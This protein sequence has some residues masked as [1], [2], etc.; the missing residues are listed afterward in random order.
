MVDWEL[1]VPGM[2][3]TILGLAGVGLSLAGIARTFVE[4]MH[5]ISALMM[6]IGMIIFA[7][8]VL[9]DGLPSS[10]QAKATVLIIVGFL[11][12]FGTFMLGIS[13]VTSLPMFAGIL[14]LILIPTA[15]IAW[16]A[17]KQSPHL[18]A[19]SILFSSASVVGVI[20]FLSFGLVAPQPIEAGV[21]E[22]P[23]VVEEELEGPRVEVKIVEGASTLDINAFDPGEITVEKG[24][25]IVWTNA[26]SVIHTV[27]SG[28]GF[29]DANYGSLFDSSNIKAEATFSLDTGKLEGGEYV[30][31]CTF[32]PNMV[33]KFT[34]TGE[35]SQ[36]VAGE[37][38]E[39][40]E[41]EGGM[42]VPT[43]EG[44]IA[45][46]V[47][48]VDIVAGAADVNNP[49][50][51]FP[52]EINVE[53]NTRVVWTNKDT[54]GHTITSGSLGDVDF[55]S[56]FDSSFPL[57]MANATFD[58]VFDTSGEYPYFCQ[59]HPWMVGKVIVE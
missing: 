56:L 39:E 23:P 27:T 15:A 35:G 10:N 25:I 33:G 5:A 22:E 30:Y 49:D 44:K 20:V 26:D 41:E 45:A 38:V 4:G 24:T 14:L 6:F 47:V 48:N 12:A 28:A 29:D 19:I 52:N 17:N 21:I 59:V 50:F 58:H 31:F 40:T 3:L 54:A 36:E 18:K 57:L 1:L 55:G 16:A 11:V 46:P 43:E 37:D 53:I 51:Y 34:I 32:H 8:G 7:A 13:T 2:G 42:E 9:K